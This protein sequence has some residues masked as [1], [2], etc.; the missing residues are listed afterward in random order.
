MEPQ[1]EIDPVPIDLHLQRVDLLVVGDDRI[2]PVLVALEQPLPGVLEIAL[3][4]AGHHERVVAKL[5]QSFLEGSE[6]VRR[7]S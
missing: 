3:R 5:A 7:H 2:T 4:Q 6:N 1:H